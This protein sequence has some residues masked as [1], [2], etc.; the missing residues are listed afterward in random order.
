[1]R[2]G[3]WPAASAAAPTRS[4]A[5]PPNAEDAVQ[6]A[7]V[8]IRQQRQHI[9]GLLGCI[10]DLE[11]DLPTDATQRLQTDNTSLRLQVRQLTAKNRI[12]GE[13]LAAARA[14]SRSHESAIPDLRAETAEL[15]FTG[16][17]CTCATSTS[18][19]PSAPPP[20][21]RHCTPSTAAA[22][23][24]SPSPPA[25]S[26]T[27]PPRSPSPCPCPSRTRR[28]AS[29]D[30]CPK[31]TSTASTCPPPETCRSES[32]APP[33]PTAPASSRSP[34]TPPKEGQPRHPV[35]RRHRD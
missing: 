19:S 31:S 2:A 7:H 1:M 3:G 17:G 32:K 11:T 4:A 22:R 34:A 13:W 30:A 6:T 33:A 8:E 35:S 9:G 18:A 23:P 27:S 24:G 15:E 28:S 21:P 14:N 12:L 5:G 20:R 25:N 29:T 26:A 16:P 10:R